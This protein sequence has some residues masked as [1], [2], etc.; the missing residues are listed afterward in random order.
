MGA[1]VTLILDR[2]AH[3]HAPVGAG[4]TLASL[5]SAK[6]L[7]WDAVFL[8]GMSDG[9]VPISLADSPEQVAEE[10]R[11][12]YVGVTRAR[13]HLTLSYAAARN[14]GGAANRRPS[15]FLDGLWPEGNDAVPARR[16]RSA[17][18]AGVGRP[19]PPARELT[20]AEAAIHERLV[21]WRAAEAESASAPAFAIL[22]D[23]TL[24]ALAAASPST[25]RDLAA[26]RGIGPVKI[27]RYG[28]A[29]LSIIRAP[30]TA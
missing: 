6:G 14:E 30:S 1:L 16:S 4:V 22:P 25:I 8:A 10:R 15:R 7:E 26:V 24:R 28:R 12:L 17:C 18:S 9:L 5:H 13:E 19:G 21:A 27:E 23:V 11:L 2:Q 20:P 29:L 3:D